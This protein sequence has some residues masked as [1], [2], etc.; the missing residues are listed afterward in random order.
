MSKTRKESI[1]QLINENKFL[2]LEE[3]SKYLKVS[4][5][6]IRR[7]VDVLDKEGKIIKVK[8]GS[9]L[10]NDYKLYKNNVDFFR[11]K[12]IAKFASS[13]IKDGDIIVIDGGTTTRQI[14]PHLINKKNLTVFT[15]CLDIANEI[16]LLEN[17]EI[18]LIMAGGVLDYKVNILFSQQGSNIMKEYNFDKGFLSCMGISL[19]NGVTNLD[20]PSYTQ[21]R[22][23]IE[24]SKNTYFLI[25]S[26]KF[27]KNS[28]Q[29]VCSIKEIKNI[30][31]DC[32]LDKE[33]LSKYKKLIPNIYIADVE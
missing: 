2:T 15:Q 21:K 8:G 19:K 16:S 32:D 30:I 11:K 18:T 4:E 5:N 9:I 10:R 20:L 12:A 13:F 24:N 3:L 26:T 28:L 6:T 7:D 29:K 1:L 31:I 14:I 22:V 23:I 33:I 27:D 25:D 17:S